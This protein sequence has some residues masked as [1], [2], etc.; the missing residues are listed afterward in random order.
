[1]KHPYQNIWGNPTI[2]KNCRIAAFVEIGKDVIVGDRCFIEAFAF[3]PPGVVLEDDCFIGPH[4]CFTNDKHP[5]SKNWEK[6]FVN[7]GAVI[8]ANATI[9]PGVVIGDHA[10][11]GAGSVVVNDIPSYTVVAGNPAKQIGL[12]TKKCKTCKK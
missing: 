2:G 10:V 12:N 8:G 7:H 6:T 3:L 4:V 1:M 9:L 11:I 5:P